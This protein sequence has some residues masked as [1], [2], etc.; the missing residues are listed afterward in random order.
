MQTADHSRSS[1]PAARRPVPPTVALLALAGVLLGWRML[2]PLGRDQAVFYVLG[3]EAWH[4][5]LPYR[6]LFEHKPPGVL[7]IYALAA[8]LD[9]GDGWGIGLFDTAAAGATAVLLFDVVLRWRDRRSAWLAAVVYLVCCRAQC[10]GGWWATGQP[11]AFQ[12]LCVVAALRCGQRQRWFW[13]GLATW[14][15]LLLKF[16]YVGLIPVLVLWAGRGGAPAFMGGLLVP[17]ATLLSVGAALGALAPAWQAVIQFNL[18]HAQVESLPWSRLP[19][20]LLSRAARLAIQ[21]PAVVLPGLLA[22][23]AVRRPRT[24][25]PVG[26]ALAALLQLLLQRKLWLWHWN[27]LVLPLVLAAAL[28]LPDR[29]W[30]RPRVL[31]AAGALVL[32]PTLV[33][34]SDAVVRRFSPGKH[35]EVLARYV[36]GHGD[37][38]AAEVALVG[39]GVRQAAHSGDKLL[40]WGF[41]PGVY[42]SSGLS[43]GT[44]WIYDYPLTVGLAPSA[45]DL[46]VSDIIGRLPD[47]RWWVVFRNDANS[48]ERLDSSTQLS[49]LPAL[50]QALER[51]YRLVSHVA[52]A[53]VYERVH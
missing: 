38:S 45:R 22:L 10:F 5:L 19:G 42:L 32:L 49:Q 28:H 33:G 53:D 12:D 7:V 26:L 52:D 34:T 6:D 23:A 1:P 24:W 31:A 29:L 21:V 39:A 35:V 47:I 50:Q 4:G 18:R 46:A 25:L 27:P 11:E 48:L 3:R 9:G 40:V 16:T 36:W 51:D 13:S 37:F 43:P 15:A 2:E 8:L 17:T 20:A 41:E 44:R 14:S 30:R